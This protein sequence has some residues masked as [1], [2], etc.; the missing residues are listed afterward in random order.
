MEFNQVVELISE[1]PENKKVPQL[2][3][4]AY[5]KA[6][7]EDKLLIGR[8]TEAL[9]NAANTEKDFDLISKSWE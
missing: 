1:W 9:Y 2:I 4:A 5:D 6:T 3:R 8:S 7:G